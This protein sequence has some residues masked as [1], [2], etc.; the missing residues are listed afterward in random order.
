MIISSYVN[1]ASKEKIYKQILNL[2]ND[3]Y[4]GVLW[5]KYTDTAVDF[6]P[7]IRRLGR[8]IEAWIDGG[9]CNMVILV[10]L[11]MVESRWWC[12]G[13]CCTVLLTLMHI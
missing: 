1:S 2:H 7:K 6:A 3:V 4:V 5:G 13:V 10:I 12:V 8:W 9:N 11:L